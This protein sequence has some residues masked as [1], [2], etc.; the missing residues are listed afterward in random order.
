MTYKF[1]LKGIFSFQ[2]I[3][4]ISRIAFV[5]I[6]IFFSSESVPKLSGSKRKVSKLR[7]TLGTLHA[8]FHK[9]HFYKPLQAEVFKKVNKR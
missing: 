8:F 3:E 2:V 4:I 6:G 5:R 9:Q 1:I 7:S